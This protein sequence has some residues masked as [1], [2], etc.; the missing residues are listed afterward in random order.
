MDRQLSFEWGNVRFIVRVTFTN[1][2]DG[3]IELHDWYILEGRWVDTPR[4]FL[5][6][7][8]SRCPE[9]SLSEIDTLLRFDRPA[10]VERLRRA[11]ILEL[12]IG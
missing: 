1:N 6:S 9:C 7:E 10:F 11:C 12:E 5:S 2:A 8:R 4:R 3:A